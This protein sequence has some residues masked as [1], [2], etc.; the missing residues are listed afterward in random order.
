MRI[1]TF[2]TTLPCVLLALAGFAQSPEPTAIPAPADMAD[3]P[4]TPAQTT[5]TT[6]QRL[7]PA[8]RGRQAEPGKVLATAAGNLGGATSY[9]QDMPLDVQGL[10][11]MRRP[12]VNRPEFRAGWVTRFDWARGTSSSDQMKRRISDLMEGARN[13]RMNAVLFQVRG[14]ATVLYPSEL[15]PWSQ[16]LGG[17]DPGFDPLK[18]AI[19]QAHER[20]LEFH[21]YINPVPVSEER[22]SAPANPKHIWYKHC[23]PESVP[24]WLVYKDGKPAPFN[25]YKWLNTNLPDVQTYIRTVVLDLVKR[26]D[27]DGVHYDRIRFPS[28]DVSDDPWSKARFEGGANPKNLEFGE[29]QTDNITRMLTDI[30]GAIM[31]IKPH[32]KVSGAV[33]G[34][35]D[36]TRLPQGT[37]HATGY[38]WTSSGLQDYRQDSIGWINRGCMDALVPMIYWNMGDMKPDYD[39]MVLSFMAG[40]KNGRHVYGG[41]RVFQPEEMLRQVVATNRIGAHGTCPFTLGRVIRG[42]YAE[43]YQ[44]NIYPI[45]APVPEMP[46][47][48][49]PVFGHVVAVVKDAD[50]NPVV[51]A[52]VKVSGKNEVALSSADG[53]CAILDVVPGEVTVEVSKGDLKADPKKTNVEK[54]EVSDFEFTLTK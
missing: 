20:N 37:D 17:K 36:N 34:I 41:Q 5:L 27:V 35:Y 2:T 8:P 26:Y 1:R 7:R 6:E 33:W 22:T 3:R 18:Y 32:V 12:F 52:H 29:W 4:V 19:E 30:Y 43:F 21:A 51:D 44:K 25:E 45:E 53:F 40:I 50:G 39:E 47:K 10:I 31:Q 11:E 28:P 15:E 24:N 14:D 16:L 46:W 48:T 23:A 49:N 13:L 42:D 9:T 38:S 54:G